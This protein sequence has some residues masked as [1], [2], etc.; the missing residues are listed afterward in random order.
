MLILTPALAGAGKEV[1]LTHNKFGQL[2]NIL[3]RFVHKFI[4]GIV[5]D[6][7]DLQLEKVPERF[8]HEFNDV[9]KVQDIRLVQ[10]EKVPCKFVI[11]VAFDGNIILLRLTQPSNMPTACDKLLADVGI[12]TL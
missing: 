10:P 3:L 4:D 5:I 9:G 2:L 1:N 7:S 11:P 8:V 6:S 12:T